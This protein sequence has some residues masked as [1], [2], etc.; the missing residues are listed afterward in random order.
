[1]IGKGE[2]TTLTQKDNYHL[3]LAQ[4]RLEQL[5]NDPKYLQLSE[6]EKKQ[7]EGELIERAIRE[8]AAAAEKH[9]SSSSDLIV[10]KFLDPTK[11]TTLAS[12]YLNREKS[13][14]DLKNVSRGSAGIPIFK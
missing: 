4:A 9:F 7:K 13:P 12:Y 10:K 3:G 2:I 11:L 5:K 1:M 8:T 14:H 6:A